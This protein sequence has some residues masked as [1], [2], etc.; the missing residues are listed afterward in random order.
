M[1]EELLVVGDCELWGL[2]Y[3]RAHRRWIGNCLRAEVRA[4]VEIQA[5]YEKT[6]ELL[7]GAGRSR[8]RTTVR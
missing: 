5:L 6:A 7:K 1:T 2:H 4:R 8:N 3:C